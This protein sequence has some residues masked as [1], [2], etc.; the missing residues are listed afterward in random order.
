MTSKSIEAQLAELQNRVE[1]LEAAIGTGAERAV[2]TRDKKHSPKEFLMD[3][4][5]KADTQKVL[6]LAFY[7]EQFE[8]LQSFNV[9]DIESVFR[10]AKEKIPAN[11]ND[12][13]NKNITRGF[14]MEAEEK[15]DSKKAW[16]L[17]ST[18]ERY[19]ENELTK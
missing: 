1:K 9:A 18:G 13:V 15:K 14:M 8:G 4:A 3:K 12:A 6:A 17:T 5:V 16:G 11:I 10:L 7:L 19:V 2:A